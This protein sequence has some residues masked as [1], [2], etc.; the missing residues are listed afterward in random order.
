MPNGHEDGSVLHIEDV[1]QQYG[2]VVVLEDVDLTVATGEFL[3]VVGPSGCGKST[4]FRIVIGQEFPTSGE[5]YIKGK[6][7]SVPDHRRGVVYQQ[8]TLLPNLTIVE[9]VLVGSKLRRWP[10]ARLPSEL[11]DRAHHYLETAGLADQ[12]TKYPSELSG[13]QRQRAAIVQ[14]VFE[15]PEILCMD[16]PFSALDPETREDMQM[17]ILELWEKERMTIL[18]VTHDLEEGAYLGTRMIGLSK[19]YSDDRGDSVTRGAR[20]ARDVSLPYQVMGPS[21]K[22]DPAFLEQIADFRRDVFD[23][24]HRQHVTKFELTHPSSWQTLREDKHQT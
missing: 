3:T 5:V 2:N 14:S 13:G 11:Y 17:F 1:H 6:P 12:A 7:L 22:T 18:F 19:Y 20:I 4:L 8:S 21:V 23:P 15:H 10:F 9:N 24:K 16:E